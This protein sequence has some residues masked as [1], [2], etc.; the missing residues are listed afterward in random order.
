MSQELVSVLN[1]M[2]QRRDQHEVFSD[3]AMILPHCLSD[4]S[5]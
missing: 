3:E 5:R 2:T 4:V 1:S